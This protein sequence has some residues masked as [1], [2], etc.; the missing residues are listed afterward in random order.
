MQSASQVDGGGK[1]LTKTTVWL[2][3][4]LLLKYLVSRGFNTWSTETVA[5]PHVFQASGLE[6]AFNMYLWLKWY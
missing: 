4:V 2:G 5:E 6:R 3:V 1:A